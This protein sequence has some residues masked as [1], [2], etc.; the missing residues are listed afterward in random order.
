MSVATERAEALFREGFSCSQAV[1]VTFSAKY[2][3]DETTALKAASCFGGGVQAAEVCGAVSGAVMV[4]GLKDGYTDPKDKAAKFHG[5]G[6]TAEFV[7]LFRERYGHLTCSG[8]LGCNIMTPE[9]KQ[10]ALDAKLFSTACPVFVAGA[11]A[12]LEEMEY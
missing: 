9:G 11:V 12:I 8:L 1:A 10:Q 2:G 4:I 5:L 7:R 6:K 3:L